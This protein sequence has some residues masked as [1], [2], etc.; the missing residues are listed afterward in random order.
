MNIC[1][2]PGRFNGHLK[3]CFTAKTN[4]VETNNALYELFYKT[5]TALVNDNYDG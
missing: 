3:L 4:T 1:I 5:H 2:R